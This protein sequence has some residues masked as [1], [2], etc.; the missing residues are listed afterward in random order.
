MFSKADARQLRSMDCKIFEALLSMIDEDRERAGKE[1]CLLQARLAEFFRRQGDREP[2]VAADE[3][4]DRVAW[5]LKS[6]AT[7]PNLKSYCYGVARRVRL[8]R[9]RRE[10]RELLAHEQFYVRRPAESAVTETEET[11]RQ[12]EGQLNQLPESDRRLL[13]LYYSAESGEGRQNNRRE[14]AAVL[15]LTLNSLRIR[16]HRL[17]RQV[18]CHY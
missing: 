5:R 11:T 13:V 10:M 12:Q 15:G 16:I 6:G 17:R 1:Y 7:V 3:T 9:Y 2:E 8:E 14:L 18:Y 4:L